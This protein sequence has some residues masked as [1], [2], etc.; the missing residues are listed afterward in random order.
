MKLKKIILTL[1]ILSSSLCMTSC[2][3]G[4][5]RNIKRGNICFKYLDDYIYVETH[6]NI[7]Y[8]IDPRH[9]SVLY[10]ADGSAMTYDDYI[11]LANTKE[12]LYD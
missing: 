12:M 3:V 10:N 9:L 4:D 11:E 5:F 7:I 1:L 8:Y 2:D 6:T